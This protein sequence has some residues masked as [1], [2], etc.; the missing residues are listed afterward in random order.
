MKLYQ[1]GLS[2]YMGGV[3]THVRAPRGEIVGWSPAAARRHRQWV[4]SVDADALTGYGY[5]VTLT[6]KHTPASAADF[7]RIRLAWIK[8]VERLAVTRIH[9][10]V[11]WQERGTPHIHA[12]VYFAEEQ[13]DFEAGWLLW[14]WVFVAADMGAAP[15]AQVWEHISGAV[16][17]LKYLAKHATRGVAHYQRQG[18]PEGWEKTGRL[19]GHR[20]AWPVVEPLVLDGLNNREFWRLRRIARAWAIADA[21][22][23]NDWQRVKFLRM[24]GR[25][26]NRQRSS[27]QGVSEWMP[28]DVSLRL[29]DLFERENR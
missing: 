19:W 5:A 24:A 4:Q 10:V 29:V 6:M 18:H 3:G 25:S 16:G 1:N 13:T 27:F 26:S 28:I 11:E 17:W 7:E 8:R 22:K 23:V 9:W 15:Q 20:G 14:H 12:A 2:A 21:R